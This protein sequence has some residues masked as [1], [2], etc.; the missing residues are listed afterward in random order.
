MKDLG[1]LLR[2]IRLPSPIHYNDAS[3][4]QDSIVRDLLDIKANKKSGSIL[5]MVLT[6]QLKPV[7]TTGRRERGSM[8]AETR[9]RLERNGQAS[10]VESLRGGQTT[11]HG[12][13]QL[14][15]YPILDISSTGLKIRPRCYVDLLE[16]AII[17]TLSN[18]G[19]HAQRTENTGVW[20]TDEKKIAAIGVHLRRNI[21]SHGIGLNVSTDLSFFDHIIGCGLADKKTT[22]MQA[23]GFGNTIEEVT[24]TFV[25]TLA[26]KLG[27][28]GVEELDIRSL[29]N[30]Q[31]GQKKSD[32]M[33]ILGH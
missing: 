19:L 29:T 25:R 13:G 30:L 3:F 24:S 23:E 31:I 33:T 17:T 16:E 11:F 15:A 26:S 27:L 18:F 6:M 8:S 10:V 2:H 32:I 22:S 20:V 1:R 21:T 12:P 28:E 7:Y 4:Y 14:V 5:P 9:S